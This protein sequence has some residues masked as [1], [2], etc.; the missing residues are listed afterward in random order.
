MS[1]VVKPTKRTVKLKENDLVA[2]IDD[3]VTEAVAVKKQEWLVEQAKKDLN[4]TAV[5]EGKFKALERQVKMLM[6]GKK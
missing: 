2:L 3:I 5:L 4:K 6:E 1:N